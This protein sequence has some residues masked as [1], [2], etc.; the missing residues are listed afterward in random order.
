[1]KISPFESARQVYDRK[2][3]PVE[4]VFSVKNQGRGLLDE[5]EKGKKE[6]S[7]QEEE[8]EETGE[9][10]EER[11]L[12]KILGKNSRAGTSIKADDFNFVVY[13]VRCRKRRHS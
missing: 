3:K 10:V 11:D 2:L 1:M 8:R 9:E 12:L 6:R 4:N 13:D 7:S 5:K